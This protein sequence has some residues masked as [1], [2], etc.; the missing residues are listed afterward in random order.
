MTILKLPESRASEIPD[1]RDPDSKNSQALAEVS[2]L[3]SRA[4]RIVSEIRGNQDQP[5]KLSVKSKILRYLDEKPEVKVRDLSLAIGATLANTRLRVDEL[6]LEGK[7]ERSKRGWV[8]IR[9]VE[10]KI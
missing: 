10:E 4:F 8:R 2:A 1:P 3:L 7:L 9:G 6:V 5:K